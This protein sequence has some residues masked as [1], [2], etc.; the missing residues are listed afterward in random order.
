MSE[1]RW[2]VWAVPE[3]ALGVHRASMLRHLPEL[4]PMVVVPVPDGNNNGRSVRARRN[5]LAATDGNGQW[6]VLRIGVHTRERSG[7]VR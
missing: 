1:L 6:R 4:K 7:V 5:Q 2:C 3:G